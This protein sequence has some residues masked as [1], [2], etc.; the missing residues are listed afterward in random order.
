MEGEIERLKKL[1]GELTIT[2][3]AFKKTLEGREKLIRS[4]TRENDS[5]Y[6]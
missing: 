5:K 3:D 6:P 4:T 2:N 1:I